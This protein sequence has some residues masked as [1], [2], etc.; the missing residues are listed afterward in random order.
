MFRSFLFLLAVLAGTSS[1]ISQNLQLHFDPRHAL[2]SK[3]FERNVVTATFEMFKP[4]KWGST[5]MFTDLDFNQSRGNLGMAYLEIARDQNL[6]NLPIKAH[7][8]YNGG[9]ASWGN[10][11]NA[12]LVGL[13]YPFSVGK[14]FINTYAAYKYQAFGKVSNDIQWTATWSANFFDNKLTVCGFFDFWTENKNREKQDWKSGKKVVIISEPQFWYNVDEHLAFGTE[15]E[16][17]HNFL[18]NRYFEDASFV[19]PTIAVKWTF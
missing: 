6:G 7:L 11:P 3:D 9:Y 5:F 2:H 18:K 19:N 15:I 4:D 12:Y 13:S 8:E 17:S 1:L 10:I 16:I 14:F